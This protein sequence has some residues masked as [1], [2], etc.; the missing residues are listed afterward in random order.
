MFN[1]IKAA[2]NEVPAYYYTVENPSQTIEGNAT[3]YAR[4]VSHAENNFVCELRSILVRNTDFNARDLRVDF[5]LYKNYKGRSFPDQRFRDTLREL[6]PKRQGVRPDLVIHKKQ[7]NLEPTHQRLALECKTDP[8][9]LWSE[10]CE[11]LFK[12]M[13]YRKLFNFQCVCYLIVNSRVATM[14]SYYRDYANRY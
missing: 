12:L 2:T 9:L 11:D 6:F 3:G 13:I 4:P 1:R 7:A 10:F 5:D 14:D 8:N